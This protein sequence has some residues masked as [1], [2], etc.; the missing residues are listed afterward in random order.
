VKHVNLDAGHITIPGTI[1]KNDRTRIIP[2]PEVFRIQ[3]Q[4]YL[5]GKDPQL[6]L[7]AKG[8]KPGKEKIAPTRI[9]E[10]FREVADRLGFTKDVQFYGLKDTCAENLIR[11][12]AHAKTIQ[13][14][15][16][17]TSLKTTDAY[18]SKIHA[19]QLEQLRDTFPEFGTTS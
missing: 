1:A 9:A 3:L 14:L 5:Q 11:A 10:H 7:C 2:I 19:P 4:E 16:D 12:G 15:F 13:T 6:L 18:M 8:F 17:H